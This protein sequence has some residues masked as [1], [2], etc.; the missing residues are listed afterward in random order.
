MGDHHI[1]ESNILID[2]AVGKS[3]HCAAN[4]DTRTLHEGKRMLQD[5]FF[6][7]GNGSAVRGWRHS[8]FFILHLVSQTHSLCAHTTAHRGEAVVSAYP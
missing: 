3:N 2:A 4:K 7:G 8:S 5:S 1:V 6:H